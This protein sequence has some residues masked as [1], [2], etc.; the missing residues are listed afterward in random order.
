MFIECV[1]V[2]VNYSDFLEY[3]LPRNK[4]QV[5]SIII[6]T[7]ETDTDTQ[8]VC[9]DNGVKFI[10][11]DKFFEGGAQFNKGKGINVGFSALNKSDWLLHIDADMILPEDFAQK[12]KAK[13]LDVNIIYGAGRFLCP[14]YESWEKYVKA[15]KRRRPKWHYQ[16]RSI[17]IAM[18]FFQ[19]FNAK[20]ATL[21]AEAGP[22]YPEE[23]GHAGRSD[24]IFRRKFGPNW[25]KIDDIVPIHIESQ[26]GAL[27]MNWKGRA[28]P[29]F[30][31]VTA[32]QA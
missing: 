14:T 3:S 16:G 31:P 19:L 12:I 13:N 6:V 10:T 21:T 20:S 30:G 25:K 1:S 5:D 8:K 9:N 32:K 29:K 11:T 24:R 22:W 28:T 17:N 26:Q 2:C 18:G 23:F 7:T 27:G 4:K 15:R